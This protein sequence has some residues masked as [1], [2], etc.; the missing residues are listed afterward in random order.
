MA[1]EV[2]S[3]GRRDLSH[4]GRPL[5]F[6]TINGRAAYRTGTQRTGKRVAVSQM[7]L[8]R[9]AELSQKAEN[10]PNEAEKLSHGDVSD[11]YTQK[12]TVEGRNCAGAT[13]SVMIGAP[14]A[15]PNL[16]HGAGRR[17]GFSDLERAE[18]RPVGFPE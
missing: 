9:L 4:N 12:D 17:V 1:V 15:F 14:C 3:C 13:A 16:A 8:D 2:Y 18:C 10:N 11:V 6:E 7:G 5:G